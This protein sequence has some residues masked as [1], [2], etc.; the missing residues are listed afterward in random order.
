MATPYWAE[1]FATATYLLNRRPCS[2]IQNDIPYRF[3]YS[4]PPDHGTPQA[5]SSLHSLCLPRLSLISQGLYFLL[6]T[7]SD[8]PAPTLVA[9]SSN[10]EQSRP[11]PIVLQELTD[12]DPAI[13][14]RRPTVYPALSVGGTPPSPSL[15]SPTGGSASTAPLGA[16]PA[17]AVGGPPRRPTPPGPL[18]APLPRH[19]IRRPPAAPTPPAPST[20]AALAP[21]APTPLAPAPAPTVPSALAPPA[22]APLAPPV[23]SSLPP[24]APLRPVTRSVTGA[25][26]RVHYQGLIASTSS[27]SSI[28]ANYRSALADANWRA[29][30][31]DEFQALIDNDTCRL[32]PWSPGA[33]VVSGKWIF[34]H[35]F[36]ADGSLARHKA[37]WVVRGFCQR[38][39]IDYD[40]AFNQVVKP[41]TIRTVLS[42]ATSRAWPIHQLDMKNAFLHKHLTETVYCQQPPGFVD[43]TTQI[44]SVSCRSPCMD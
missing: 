42:I 10:V 28:L 18:V 19:Y 33:N 32:V 29:A 25:I 31:V 36:H 44:T 12:D 37:R 3:L 43:P 26:E 6:S 11:S 35:K 38:H 34:R 17:P 40:E 20:P 15:V 24:P 14:V 22:P 8:A 21:S 1:A 5:C 16:V 7:P 13:L 2:A 39:G 41:V 27:P 30:M 9:P 4:Q 23:P